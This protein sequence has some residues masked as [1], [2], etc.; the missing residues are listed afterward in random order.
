MPKPNEFEM[1]R[2]LKFLD[3]FRASHAELPTLKDLEAEG[4][5]KELIAS[6][7]KSKQVV[8]LYVT[9]TNGAVVKGYKR[10][11]PGI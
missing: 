7:E 4:F 10:P 11:K 5:A 1:R 9:M 8:K 2:L 3:S 6:A